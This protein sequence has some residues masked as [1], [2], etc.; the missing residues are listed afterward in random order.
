V[1]SRFDV[2]RSGAVTLADVDIVRGLLGSSAIGGEWES[3][4]LARCDLDSSGT[5]EI[6][7]LTLVLAK[8]ESTVR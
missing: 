1:F 3:E 4:L 6:A 5:I 2:D 7:D 8:Y